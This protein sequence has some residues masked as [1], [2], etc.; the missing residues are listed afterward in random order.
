MVSPEDFDFDGYVKKLGELVQITDVKPDRIESVIEQA[1]EILKKLIEMT[2]VRLGAV[3]LACPTIAILAMCNC[4]V[5]DFFSGY[6]KPV[7]AYETGSVNMI[8]EHMKS[9][10]ENLSG[11]FRLIGIREYRQH[12]EDMKRKFPSCL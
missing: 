7:V 1:I 2:P 4:Y 8:H 6:Y 3:Q 5:R 12:V 11:E 9:W 10:Y